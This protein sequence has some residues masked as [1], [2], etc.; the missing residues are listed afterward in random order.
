MKFGI[1]FDV[2]GK[3]CTAAEV[4]LERAKQLASLG[5]IT[6]FNLLVLPFRLIVIL[7]F[8]LWL[9]VDLTPWLYFLLFLITLIPFF[10]L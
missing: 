6:L 9:V 1:S 2:I 8:S 5:H 7:Y 10:N 3:G 4:K